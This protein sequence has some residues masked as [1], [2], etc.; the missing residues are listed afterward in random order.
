MDLV[1]KI[2][3]NAANVRE[4]IANAAVR[5]GRTERD[6]RLV[7]VSKGQPV[8]VIQAAILAGV[9]DL[10][11]NYPEETVPK[12]LECGNE[13]VTWHMIGHLQ[14]RKARLV[15]EYFD[16]IH[17]ID[18]LK[19]AQKM[20]QIL[21]SGGRRL[22]ALLQFNVGGEESKSGWQ[23]EDESSWPALLEEIEPIMRLPHLKVSGL[24]TMPPLTTL[25]KDARRYFRKLVK[26]QAYLGG[27]FPSV[28][29][30]ELSMGTSADYETAVEEGATMV[31]I[32]TSVLGPRPP[33]SG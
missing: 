4:R 22:P 10:G 30:R 15:C 31:R 18:S 16:W 21:A 11:E 29:W 13:A 25:P 7:V 32:G 20:D 24:M 33:R 1:E 26:L 9:S 14:S 17:T 27:Q 6:V 23:A 28:D 19:L 12:I 5:G 3:A 2:R 8:E